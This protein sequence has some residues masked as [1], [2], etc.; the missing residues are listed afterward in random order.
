MVRSLNQQTPCQLGEF[1]VILA[2]TGFLAASLRCGLA[3]RSARVAEWPQELQGGVGC[4]LCLSYGSW[5]WRSSPGSDRNSMGT[6]DA[7]AA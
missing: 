1:R 5:L 4:L 2:M 7:G 6:Q 3:D